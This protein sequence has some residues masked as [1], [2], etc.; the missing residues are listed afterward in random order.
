MINGPTAPP[1][2]NQ[3][4]AAYFPSEPKIRLGPTRPQMTDAS[5]NTWSPGH[6]H[7]LLWGKSSSWHMCSTEFSSHHATARLIVPAIMVPI[8][9]LTRPA[10]VHS[11]REE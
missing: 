2:K 7:G 10:N 3:L 9:W 1:K 5:K 8:N 4:R 6:V 11:K